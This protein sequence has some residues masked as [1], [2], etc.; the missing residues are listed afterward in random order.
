MDTQITIKAGFIEQYDSWLGEIDI[1]GCAH[2]IRACDL[3]VKAMFAMGRQ[4]T[5]EFV[6]STTKPSDNDY[7]EFEWSGDVA[8]HKHYEAQ[9]IKSWY[10][11]ITVAA[12][13]V[14][15]KALFANGASAKQ[16]QTIYVWVY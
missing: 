2:T 11:S 4:Q 1:R 13:S 15:R 7:H 8:R 14:I 12:S 6:L 10:A 16:A 9:K 3:D 5:A